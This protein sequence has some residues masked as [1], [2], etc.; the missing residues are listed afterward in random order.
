M[1]LRCAQAR[2]CWLCIQHWMMCA[3]ARALAIDRP[4]PFSDIL[5]C[6][7]ICISPSTWS[8]WPTRPLN[9]SDAGLP[10]ADLLPAVYSSFNVYVYTYVC[11]LWLAVM[12]SYNTVSLISQYPINAHKTCCVRAAV[13]ALRAFYALTVLTR[14]IL[15]FLLRRCDR[16]RMDHHSGHCWLGDVDA[17]VCVFWSM[18]VCM[19]VCW[20]HSQSHSSKWTYFL[21]H[22][23]LSRS[24]I[25]FMDSFGCPTLAATLCQ[26][27]TF[28][29]HR[30]SVPNHN[31]WCIYIHSPINTWACLTRLKNRSNEV[32]VYW[33]PEM[34][35]W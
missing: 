12:Q 8:Q 32:V 15:F 29:T 20:C 13:D 31:A 17:C 3:E 26:S 14:S 24:V 7:L 11:L 16:L 27:H 1:M 28:T 5:T 21:P 35:Y 25:A 23:C 4:N 22:R 10:S 6:C 34:V 30:I 19:C 33:I 2:V 18:C 9:V